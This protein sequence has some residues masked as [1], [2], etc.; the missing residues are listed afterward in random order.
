VELFQGTVYAVA[1]RRLGNHAEVQEVSQEVFIQAFCKLDQLRDPTCFA[2]WLRSMAV[3]MSINRAMRRGPRMPSLSEAFDAV[4]AEQQTP[5]CRVLDQE[6]RTKVQQGL[7]R[8]SSLD[9]ETLTAFYFDGRSLIEM[10]DQ[11]NSPVGTIKRRLHVA[12]KRLARELAE[13]APA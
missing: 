3:R 2:G 5:L 1:Y 12:R 13:M 7:H 4:G 6:R 9:R 8:L 11:F 10:S